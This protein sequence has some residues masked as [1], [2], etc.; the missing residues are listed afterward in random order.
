METHIALEW[1][2][3]THNTDNLMEWNGDT[4]IIV[5]TVEFYILLPVAVW[6][7]MDVCK[8]GNETLSDPGRDKGNSIGRNGNIILHFLSKEKQLSI[9]DVHS[10]CT[11]ESLS[12]CREVVPLS[13]VANV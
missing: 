13:E 12:Y 10:K 4:H 5:H 3:D 2:G 6:T 1:N 9:G 7:G 11:L 8:P